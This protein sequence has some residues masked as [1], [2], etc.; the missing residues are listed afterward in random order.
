MPILALAGC[1]VVFGLKEATTPEAGIDASIDAPD[2]APCELDFTGDEFAGMQFAAHWSVP[3]AGTVTFLQNEKLDIT[4]A[5][6]GSAVLRTT[7]TVVDKSHQVRIALL[8][9]PGAE[10]TSSALVLEDSTK[11]QIY[12]FEVIDDP[13]FP[14]RMRCFAGPMA[15]SFPYAAGEHVVLYIH[16]EGTEV[17]FSTSPD[18]A[19]PIELVRMPAQNR[20]SF[21]VAIH[22]ATTTAAP[23]VSWDELRV[24]CR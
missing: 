17:V 24:T 1:D 6:M 13:N 7:T 16:H 4:M 19:T 3:Q 22:A 2:A 20:S 8:A 5:G 10:T 11:A 12:R 18:G 14:P 21:H 9:A 15:M 23:A